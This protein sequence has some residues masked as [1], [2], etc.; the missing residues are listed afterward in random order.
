MSNVLCQYF[1]RFQEWNRQRIVPSD[2]FR[3]T[4]RPRSR[5]L[6]TSNVCHH[7][8]HSCRG[9]STFLLSLRRA[10]LFPTVDRPNM[11]PVWVSLKRGQ[12]ARVTY[13]VIVAL[14]GVQQRKTHLL[15]D[16]GCQIMSIRGPSA[17]IEPHW[18]FTCCPLQ[19]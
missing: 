19:I 15:Q 12:I 8:S 2:N 7:C 18:H 16:N 14:R 11:A 3:T 6:E 4:G 9:S 17:K 1:S 5:S 13:I 10:D